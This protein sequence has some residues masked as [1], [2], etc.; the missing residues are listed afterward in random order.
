MEKK[1]LRSNID[2]KTKAEP[3]CF[4][5][6]RSVILMSIIKQNEKKNVRSYM[7]GE[8]FCWRMIVEKWEANDR[9]AVLPFFFFS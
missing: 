1:E 6:Q 5:L 7:H 2:N 9:D 3:G 8:F 4:E